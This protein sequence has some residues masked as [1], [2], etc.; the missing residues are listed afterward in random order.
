MN[1]LKGKK[2]YLSGNIYADLDNAINWRN[3]L[4]DRLSKL[5]IEIIDPCKK[6]SDNVSEIGE[7]RK[8]WME[9]I[10]NEKWGELKEKFWPI[11]R[12]DLRSVDYCSFIILKYDPSVP[13]IGTIHELCV[14]NYEKKVILLKYDK[15]QL[16]KFNPWISV[17]IKEHHFFSEWDQMF[18]YLEDVNQGKLDTSLWVI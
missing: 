13:T 3:L 15:S 12:S 14:A 17:F 1:Y 10:K 4:Y 7:D 6:T 18:K 2:V 11:V 9:L 16:D 8:K 5:G